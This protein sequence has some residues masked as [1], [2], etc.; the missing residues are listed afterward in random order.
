M[1]ADTKTVDVL[2][3]AEYVTETGCLIWMGSW[4]ATGYGRVFHGGRMQQAHRVSW[5]Q[6]NG[7]DI[8]AGHYV[9]HKCDTPACVNPDHLF[10]GTPRDNV[11]DMAAKGRH[12]SQRQQC[13][14]GHP[15]DAE[16]TRINS[17]GDRVCITCTRALNRQWIR[18][19]RRACGGA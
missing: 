4:S 3:N 14:H 16:N 11:I 1:G 5:M 8:P 7:C 10:V 9:C 6:A 2:S 19:K 13:V 15:F 18:N 17:R 12:W